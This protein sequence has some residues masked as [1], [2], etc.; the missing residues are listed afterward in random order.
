M[1]SKT[2]PSTALRPFGA[3]PRTYPNLIHFHLLCDCAKHNM[4]CSKCQKSQKRTELATPSVKRKSD[5]YFGSPASS[6]KSKSSATSNS[7]GIGKV[8]YAQ[9]CVPILSGSRTDILLHRAN[10]SAKV[11][12]IPTPL[13][14]LHAQHARRKY[15]QKLRER[16]GL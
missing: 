5:M 8:G 16:G 6:D 11:Q 15:S 1:I 7:A 2:T 12:R 14:A 10:S 13:T 9:L 3:D 4:V